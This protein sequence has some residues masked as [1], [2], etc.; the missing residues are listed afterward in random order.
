MEENEKI[1]PALLRGFVFMMLLM[2]PKDRKSERPMYW[3]R[4][5]HALSRTR[6]ARRD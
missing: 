5:S 4:A 1:R 3:C 6:S 2:T